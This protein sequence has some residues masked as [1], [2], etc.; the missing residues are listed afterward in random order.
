MLCSTFIFRFRNKSVGCSLSF[1]MVTPT[2]SLEQKNGKWLRC[3]LH[4]RLHG[5][6][7]QQDQGPQTRLL[8]REKLRYI[9]KQNTALRFILLTNERVRRA[10]LSPN[11]SFLYFCS[12]PT[13]DTEQFFGRIITPLLLRLLFRLS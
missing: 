4:E 8:R 7:Q 10:S 11:F 3:S 2:F 5:G 13:I 12:T 1:S 9:Q 6:M